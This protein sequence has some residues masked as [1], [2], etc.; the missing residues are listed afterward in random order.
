MET[1][2]WLTAYVVGF[3]LLQVLLYRYFRRGDP[4]PETTEGRVDRTG[5]PGPQAPDSQGVVHCDHCG[6]DNEAHRMV[7]YCRSC[8]ESLR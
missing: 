2:V 8:T 5:G 1:W 7:R 4:S 6:T 3:G